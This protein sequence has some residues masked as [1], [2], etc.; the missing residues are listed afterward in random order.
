MELEQ[1]FLQFNFSLLLYSF[2]EPS[3]IPLS[4]ELEQPFLQFNFSLLL[5]SFQEE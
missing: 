5:Y 1:P 3:K 2:Q 4:M